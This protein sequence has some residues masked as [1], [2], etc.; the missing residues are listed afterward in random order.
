MEI[1]IFNKNIASEYKALLVNNEL[2]LDI[3]Y[4]SEFLDIEA[5]I[6]GGEFEIFTLTKAETKQVFIYPYIKLGFIDDYS[7]YF[8]ITSPYGYAGPYCNDN[9][10]FSQGEEKFV[11]YVKSQNIVTEFVRYHFLYNNEMRFSENIKNEMNRSLVVIDL[12]KDWTSI[13]MHGISINNRNH[14]RRLER[15]GYKF[16]INES[17]DHLDEFIT[18]YYRTMKNADADKSFYFDRE[19]FQQ[20]FNSLPGKVKLAMVTKGG[21]TY[22]TVIFFVSGGFAHYYLMGRNLDYPKVPSSILLYIHIAKWAKE[23]GIEL[24]NIGG[25]RTN[26]PDDILFKSKKRYSKQIIPFYIGKRIHNADVYQQMIDKRI[27]DKG[28]DEFERAKHILQ[29]YR[30]ENNYT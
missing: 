9:S 30:L 14:F 5:S 23:S 29:F 28:I 18:M 24:I 13:W 2:S 27:N 7:E 10:F 22:S 19:Y 17:P 8:D 3:Y 6:R 12:R 15:D 25:G 4:Q 16:E 26:A 1:R 20:L 11:K 21:V